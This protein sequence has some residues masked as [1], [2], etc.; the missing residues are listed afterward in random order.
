MKPFDY[1]LYGVTLFGWS[2]SW[3]GL[4]WQLGVVDP[5]VSVFWRFLIAGMVM[6]VIASISRAPLMLSPREHIR[7]AALGLFIF[8]LNFSLYYNAGLWV[9]SGLL[10]V[11][12]ALA[13]SVIMLLDAGLTRRM[14]RLS[15]LGAALIGFIG[16]GILYAPE[17]DFSELN[18]ALGAGAMTSFVLCLIGTLS[19]SVGSV[20][21]ASSQRQGF[22][23]MTM[24]AWGM[25]YGAVYLF[26][27]N[28]YQGNTF[29]VEWTVPY[30]GGL[31]WLAIIS[32]V[33]TFSS[34]LLLV[35]R[36]GPGRAGYATVV[37]PVFALLI[38][39]ALEG[40]EW[41]LLSIL[42]IALVAGGNVLIL[43]R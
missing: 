26:A 39:S 41:T 42:G 6:V 25:M 27:W 21:S 11:A 8:S 14:P 17:I 5:E 7:P 34:Y 38:S 35:G 33:A 43:R 40:Y 23:V 9:T 36:I 10:A 22:S 13:S 30:L 28:F 29:T 37:F 1:F 4:K 16:V 24:N 19:F 12:F 15:H 18:L 2:T 32:S 20:I 3:I 31:F